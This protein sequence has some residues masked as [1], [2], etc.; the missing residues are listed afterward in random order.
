MAV[1]HRVF[2]RGGVPAAHGGT[3]LPVAARHQGDIKIMKLYIIR[4]GAP[5]YATDS[6]TPLGKRQAEAV[7]RRFSQN[8]LDLI[9]SSPMGRAK[10]TAQPTCEILRKEMKILD[11]CSEGA[12]YADLS[13]KKPDGGTRWCFAKQRTDYKNNNTVGLYYDWKKADPEFQ[14][15][16]VQKRLD[17]IAKGSDEFLADLGY[18]RDGCVYKITEPN[19]LRVGVFCHQ[20]FGLTWISH[21]LSIPPHIFWASFDM[22]FTGVTLIEFKNYPNGT[23]TPMLLQFDDQSHIYADRL[24]LFFEEGTRR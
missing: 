5:D 9:F 3:P 12:A 16:N 17:I 23:T 15:E 4:H 6:L 2:A 10:E 22:T 14:S 20:G 1:R 11:W 19:D 21:L 7:S 24:P 18:E 8:G 13:V